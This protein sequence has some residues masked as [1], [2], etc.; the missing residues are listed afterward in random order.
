MRRYVEVVVSLSLALFL[1]LL[2]PHV[3]PMLNAET[4]ENKTEAYSQDFVSNQV[5]VKFQPW[6]ERNRQVIGR[7]YNAKVRGEIDGT[8][9]HRLTL[10]KGSSPVSA[11]LYMNQDVRIDEV[12]FNYKRYIAVRPNDP[13]YASQWALARLGAEQAWEISS[14]ASNPIIIAIVD[15]GVDLDHPDLAGK[16][17]PGY[18]FVDNNNNPMDNNGH[19]TH[20]AGIAAA[21]ANNGVGISGVSWSSK[22]MPIK[23]LDDKGAGNDYLVAQGITW[24]V[25]NGANIVNLSFGG[26]QYST[27]L[28]DAV[29]Y[30]AQKGVVVIAAAGNEAGNGNPVF[31][32]AALDNVVAVG[33][34]DSFDKHAAFSNYGSYIDISAPGVSVLSTIWDNRYGYMSGTSM[35]APFVSGAASLILSLNPR[36]SRDQVEERIKQSADDLGEIGRDDKYGY[37][38]VNLARAISNL[39]GDTS[40]AGG[41]EAIRGKVL[42]EEGTLLEGARIETGARTAFSNVRGEFQ[43]TSIPSGIYHLT[44]YADG[45][46]SQRQE[47]ITVYSGTTVSPTAILSRLKGE[48]TGR[49]IDQKMRAIPGA[50]VR[51][52]NVVIPTDSR[53]WFRFTRVADGIYSVYYD[54]PGYRGQ[55]QENISVEKAP[56]QLPTVIMARL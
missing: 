24:A 50:A 8:G 13:F 5:L 55:V 39:S 20:V 46:Y 41:S 51:I 38:Q 45:Y 2:N 3:Q 27:V 52:G 26:I 37:G 6:A 12:E 23:A 15:T 36:M 29:D 33:A 25:D 7:L 28:K 32:P 42:S 40:L 44:Y 35:A 53:G 19:G 11:A 4:I 14:D 30:A 31:Y 34:T 56:T 9:F 22:I 49:V 18:N 21:V 48:I 47:Y 54:A 17:V 1:F 10:G 16:I 43:F